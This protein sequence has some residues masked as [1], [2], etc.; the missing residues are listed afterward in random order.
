[1]QE[2][3]RT[4]R[5]ILEDLAIHSLE[6]LPGGFARLVYLAGL[7]DPATGKYRHPKLS[8]E[9]GEEPTHEALARCHE[10]LFER[11]LELPLVEE[12]QELQQFLESGKAPILSE[13]TGLE[14]IFDVWIPPEA[15]GY[16]K[17][18]FRSNLQA[19]CEVFR[20][21]G[22]TARSDT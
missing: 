3:L 16:L 21:H 11:Y 1:M 6:C 14:K 22:S 9:Y 7:R 17:E 2:Q 12:Q 5:R 13:T 18:L 19:L 10:E 20:G 4:N 15:P 8:V